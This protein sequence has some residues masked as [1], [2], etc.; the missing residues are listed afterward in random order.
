GERKLTCQ[1]LLHRQARECALRKNRKHFPGASIEHIS[2]SGENFATRAAVRTPGRVEITPLSS[3]SC[4][5][6]CSPLTITMTS[7][8]TYS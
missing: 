6:S 3:L 1:H 2:G 5:R 7:G 8:C 4:A